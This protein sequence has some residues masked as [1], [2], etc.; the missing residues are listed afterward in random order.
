MSEEI[1][2]ILVGEIAEGILIRVDGK[3]THLNSH[4]LK[5][6][7]IQSMEEGKRSFQIDLSVCNYMDST[8]LGMLA[9]IAGKVKALSLPRIRMLNATERVRG[10]LESL[11][12][13]HLFDMVEVTTGSA[14]LK[15]LE[16]DTISLEERSRL[17][18]EAHEKLV[19]V[20]ASNA[21]K[22]RD[23]IGL[24]REKT[25]RPGSS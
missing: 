9:G 19:E 5:Q 6:F 18:L 24:L 23:V 8:F 3:G 13:N 11:G 21:A 15:G 20:N 7:M 25:K 1:S 4:F 14:T 17:M 12:I 10:M 2:G 16:G 22:F